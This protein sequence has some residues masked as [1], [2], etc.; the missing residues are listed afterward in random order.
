M[1]RL[2]ASLVVGILLSIPALAACADMV[3]VG[4]GREKQV[5]TLSDSYTIN[6]VQFCEYNC[7]GTVTQ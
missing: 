6:G 3:T 1:R 2:F 7:S 5:C 4:E